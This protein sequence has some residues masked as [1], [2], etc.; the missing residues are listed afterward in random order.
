M[1][2]NSENDQFNWFIRES[3]NFVDLASSSSNI[4]ASKLWN[5]L[6]G[7]GSGNGKFNT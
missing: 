3:K 7:H 6:D 1:P 5:S 2:T 4:F